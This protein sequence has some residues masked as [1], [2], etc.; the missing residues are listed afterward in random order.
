[1]QQTLFIIAKA[2]IDCCEAHPGALTARA[3][4]KREGFR[5]DNRCIYNP[6]EIK[7]R[8]CQEQ[9]DRSLI[10]VD[11]AKGGVRVPGRGAGPTTAVF[12]TQMR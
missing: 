8:L 5:A 6:N 2:Q 12:T 4:L 9:E 10:G 11:P 1:M 3:L 7:E